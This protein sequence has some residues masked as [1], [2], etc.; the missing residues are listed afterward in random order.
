VGCCAPAD[1]AEMQPHEW[2]STAGGN[3]ELNV[4]RHARRLLVK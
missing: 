3:T 1:T 4:W 2:P